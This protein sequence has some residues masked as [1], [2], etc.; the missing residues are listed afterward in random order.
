MSLK[1]TDLYP[2]LS[3]FEECHE[4]DLLS[5]TVWL[6]KAIYMFHYLPSDTF[7]ETE[8]QNVCHVLMELKVAV[9]KIHATPLHT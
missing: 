4:G 1:V 5:F 7:S 2:L 8:R 6:D 9:L 3:Y